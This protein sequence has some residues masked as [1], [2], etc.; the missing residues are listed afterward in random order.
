MHGAVRWCRA[1]YFTGADIHHPKPPDGREGD[2]IIPTIAET[3]GAEALVLHWRGRV[4]RAEGE[5][6]SAQRQADA[7]D[8]RLA[9]PRRGDVV[10]D[11]KAEARA[12]ADRVASLERLAEALAAKEA[13]A[14]IAYRAL[15][16]INTNSKADRNTKRSRRA[17]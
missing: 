1:W 4:V 11:L 8:A 2:Q 13:D 10:A 3:A 6:A 14:I 5:L 12:C 17:A 9:H 15:T 7:A 16:D